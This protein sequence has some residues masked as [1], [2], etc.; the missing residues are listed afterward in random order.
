[1]IV[2]RS[3]FRIQ[4]DRVLEILQSPRWV[5]SER[6]AGTRSHP[7][8]APTSG[9]AWPLPDRLPTP[10]RRPP[11]TSVQWPGILSPARRSQPAQAAAEKQSSA[12]AARFTCLIILGLCCLLLMVLLELSTA[13]GGAVSV[14]T[15]QVPRSG[16][17][18]HRGRQNRTARQRGLRRV[19]AAARPKPVSGIE[20]HRRHSLVGEGARAERR[21]RRKPLTCSAMPASSPNKTTKR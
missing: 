18:I 16:G 6:P 11:S 9:Q 21:P 20:V 5:G 12:A 1:M 14:Q 7:G 8:S 19:G 17:S 4:L 2:R 13:P 15:A 3:E 10:R